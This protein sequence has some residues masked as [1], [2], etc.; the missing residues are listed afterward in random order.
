MK[1]FRA[2]LRKPRKLPRSGLSVQ[3]STKFFKT[4][5]GDRESLEPDVLVELGSEE[6]LAGK[7][8]VMERAVRWKD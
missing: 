5:D 8:P 6:F 3:Y 7:D 4:E 1:F 2:F